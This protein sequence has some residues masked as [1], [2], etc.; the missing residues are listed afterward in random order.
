[1]REIRNLIGGA[2]CGS[3]SGNQIDSINPST[4]AVH[5]R[6]PDS[7][8]EDVDRAVAAAVEAFPAASDAIA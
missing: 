6:C 1:M 3:A 5:G 8:E 4:G 7:N 2:L